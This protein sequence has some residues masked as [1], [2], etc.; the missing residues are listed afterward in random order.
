MPSEGCLTLIMSLVATF[1]DV[2]KKV[3]NMFLP[4]CHSPI[5]KMSSN[6]DCLSLLCWLYDFLFSFQQ[7]IAAFLLLTRFVNDPR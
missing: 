4:C 7:L 5:C 3:V 1:Y 2:S 6:V